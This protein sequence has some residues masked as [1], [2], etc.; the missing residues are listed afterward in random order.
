MNDDAVLHKKWWWWGRRRTVLY[1]ARNNI[2]L[3][4]CLSFV[5]CFCFF[6]SIFGSKFLH[7]LPKRICS[8]R[9]IPDINC[10]S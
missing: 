7:P 3:S 5:F 10:A 6:S 1:L 8:C 4:S 9:A 2:Y